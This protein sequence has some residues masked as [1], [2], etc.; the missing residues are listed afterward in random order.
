MEEKSDNELEELQEST[1]KK[2]LL[3]S[4]R[5]GTDVAIN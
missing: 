2:K 5:D 1:I 3:N 4:A